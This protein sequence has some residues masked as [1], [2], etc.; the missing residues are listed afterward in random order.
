MVN[1][2]LGEVSLAAGQAPLGGGAL[3]PLV[4]WPT[5]HIAHHTTFQIATAVITPAAMLPEARPTTRPITA[6][7][8]S[9]MASLARMRPNRTRRR[10]PET[11][12]TPPRDA[13]TAHRGHPTTPCT[14]NLSAPVANR[15]GAAQAH[16]EVVVAT[17]QTLEGAMG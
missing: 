2:C 16:F 5:N 9:V 12:R 8:A 4:D 11:S 7:K 17:D 13:S 14:L 6:P 1:A 15:D 10:R 3:R